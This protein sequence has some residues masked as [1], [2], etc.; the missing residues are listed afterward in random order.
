MREGCPVRRRAPP[1][2]QIPESR[3]GRDSEEKAMVPKVKCHR[4]IK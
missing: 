1:E 2:G 3:A 4:A